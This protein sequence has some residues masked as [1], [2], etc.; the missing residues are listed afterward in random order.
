M[1]RNSEVYLNRRQAIPPAMRPRH[2]AGLSET[3]FTG[4]PDERPFDAQKPLYPLHCPP[5][6]RDPIA[7]DA[8]AADWQRAAGKSTG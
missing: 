5:Q 7:Q 1:Y 8:I 4:K 3:V 6:R 2:D